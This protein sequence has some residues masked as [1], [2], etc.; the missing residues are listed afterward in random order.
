MIHVLAILND[1]LIIIHNDTTVS[2]FEQKSLYTPL[3]GYYDG[4]FNYSMARRLM[5]RADDSIERRESQYYPFDG[6]LGISIEPNGEVYNHI[7]TSRYKDDGSISAEQI[8]EFQG[9]IATMGDIMFGG[10]T[11]SINALTLAWEQTKE[12]KA[13][14]L[15][16]ILDPAVSST[17]SLSIARIKIPALLKSIEMFNAGIHPAEILKMWD[18]EHLERPIIIKKFGINDVQEFNAVNINQLAIYHTVPQST[19]K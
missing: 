3:R 15:F 16:P 8:K 17:V 14:T 7:L 10:D 2:R 1:E 13:E 11:Y 19:E 12:L 4:R 9:L 5:V 6:V 18:I